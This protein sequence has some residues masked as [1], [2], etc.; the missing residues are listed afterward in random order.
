MQRK[1]AVKYLQ[2][3]HKITV[4]P[5]TLMNRLWRE[6]LCTYDDRNIR[7]T[8]SFELDQYA[9]R[10]DTL[11]KNGH[12]TSRNS[13]VGYVRQQPDWKVEL[14]RAVITAQEEAVRAGTLQPLYI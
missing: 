4:N 12:M 2:K 5:G 14:N 9:E 13:K 1:D 3:E 7:I 8:T 6:G 10:H 11:V